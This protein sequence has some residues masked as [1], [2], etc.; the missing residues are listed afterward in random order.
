MNER[1]ID[2]PDNFRIV[3]D[4]AGFVAFLAVVA[5]VFA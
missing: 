4:V 3:C 5:W 2:D 1:W